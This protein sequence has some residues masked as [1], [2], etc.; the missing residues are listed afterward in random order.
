[1]RPHLKYGAVFLALFLWKR[2]LYVCNAYQ[3]VQRH[4]IVLR[5]FDCQIQWERTFQPFILGIE[6]LVTQQKSR[7]LL[8]CQIPILTEIPDS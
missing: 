3:I 7:D 6:G 5:Q 4:I 1:M 2:I 8:L